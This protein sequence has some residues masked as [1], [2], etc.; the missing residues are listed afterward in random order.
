[1]AGNFDEVGAT[2]LK[3]NGGAASYISEEFLPQLQ[4]TKANAV[5]R[6][7]AD[8]EPI[9]GGIILAFEQVAGKLDWKIEAPADA[10][11]DEQA[12]T[13]FIETAW[14]DMTDS[15]DSVLSSVMSMITF[16]W[17]FFEV[18]YKIRKGRKKKQDDSE[19]RYD[20]GK[21][22]WK[23]WAVRAQ[24]SLV[25][26]VFDDHGA[27]VSMRQQDPVTGRI[28]EIPMEKSLLFRTS[29]FKNNPQGRSLLRNAYVPY[30]YLKRI[31][32]YEA[33]GLERDLAG[34]PI[35]DVPA[36]WL[37]DKATEGQKA[38]VA[39]LTAMVRDVKANKRA[40]LIM[41]VAY[42]DHGNKVLD[43]RLLS[44]AGRGAGA[45]D[46]IIQRY[47][48]E[49]AMSLLADFITMGHENVGSFALGTA[50]MDQWIMVVD[51]LC[52]SVADVVNKHAI[53]KL[54]RLNGMP[55]ENPPR[56]TYG[57]VQNVDLK[58]VSTY[59]SAVI[60]GGLVQYDPEL[61]AWVR[62]I[63]GMPPAN[64]EYAAIREQKELEKLQNTP[65]DPMAPLQTQHELGQQAAEADHKRGQE[66][67]DAQAKR[68]R[69]TAAT[70]AKLAPKPQ[71]AAAAKEEDAKKPVKKSAA[72]VVAELREHWG[73]K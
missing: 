28:I 43:F 45:T 9:I 23:N 57:T 1:M 53:E 52:K 20:D 40:G 44:G 5:Y 41:P 13:E 6:E 16:G 63:G 26:W 69:E 32:E 58:M 29:E 38:A 30:Y 4:G 61:E 12:A 33:M 15:W 34:M 71:D 22:G 11:A 73:Q 14:H 3:R 54:L 37:M 2:G 36:E 35:A 55:Y 65:T 8:N 39:N 48:Q 47:K 25:N 19:S 27:I 51:S 68:D 42:D 18:T 10:T 59:L 46:T 56:L 24:E 17:S 49:I 67:A 66:S 64:E 31:R 70:N 72:D 60:G 62:E 21:I 7:M 50:K